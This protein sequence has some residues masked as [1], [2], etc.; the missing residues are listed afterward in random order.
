MTYEEWLNTIDNLKNGAINLELLNKIKNVEINNNINDLLIPHLEKFI[1][2]RYTNNINKI[3]NDLGNIF[4]DINYL[5]LT[6]L[7]FQKETNYL[8][9]IIKIKQIPGDKQL[10]LAT[11]LA[12]E[13]KKVYDILS[14]EANR[15]DHTGA[16]ASIIENYRKKGVNNNE[17]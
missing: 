4:S 15:I 12:I 3:I 11:K 9:E 6:L 2:E 8:F 1:I 13:T 5:D 10:E 14:D 17:L 7:N 16:L